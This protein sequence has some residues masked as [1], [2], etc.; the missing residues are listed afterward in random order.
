M[1]TIR[2]PLEFKEFLQLFNAHQVE[3]LLVGAYASRLLNG[4]PPHPMA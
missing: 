1:A 4:P 2:L 3:Y